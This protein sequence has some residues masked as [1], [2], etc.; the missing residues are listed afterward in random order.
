[1]TPKAGTGDQTHGS[2]MAT[3]VPTPRAQLERLA[4]PP[5]RPYSRSTGRFRRPLGWLSAAVH[6]RAAVTCRAVSAEL[7]MTALSAVPG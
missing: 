1:M 2:T 5:P 6:V 3:M 7:A 4:P